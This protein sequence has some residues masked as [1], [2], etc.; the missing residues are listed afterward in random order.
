MKRSP[1]SKPLARLTRRSLLGGL[2]GATALGVPGSLFGQGQPVPAEPA[3][4]D[5]A[6]SGAPFSYDWLVDE[7]RRLARTGFQSTDGNIPAVLSDLS[8]DQYRDIRFRGE[9]ALWRELSPYEVQF[10]HLGSY[11]DRPVAVHDVS[12]GVARPVPYRQQDFHLGRNRI[13]DPLPENLGFAGVRVHYPLNDPEKLDELMVFLGASYFRAL[14]RGTHYGISGR[15]VAVDTGLP[16][17]EEFPAFTQLYLERPQER[18]RPL[19]VY[20]LLDGPSLT[21]AY[22]FAVEPGE[23]TTVDVTARLF[24]RQDIERLGLAPLTSMF[25][26]GP[27]DP[28]DHPDYRPRVHDSQ[29]LLMHSSRGEWVW[30]PLRNPK[31][32]AMSAFQETQPR[33]FGLIQRVRSF[34]S[35]EDLEARYDLRPSLWIEPKGDW[36]EGAVVLIEIPTPDETHDNI[37]AFWTP[38]E[39]A[40][41][42][43]E[44]VLRYV[45]HWGLHGPQQPLAVALET[46]VGRGGL[47]GQQEQARRLRKIVIDFVGGPLPGLPPEAEVVPVLHAQ[48][49]QASEPV[50]QFNPVTGGRRVFFDLP[51]TPE[52]T[53]ELRCRLEL[54]GQPLSETW[55]FQW[56]DI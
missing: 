49:I 12:D 35:Y 38:K 28:A 51:A 3:A 24:F 31:A 23:M 25:D 22:R 46:R 39:R 50:C 48:N 26:H 20:A 7:A 5:T 42:G 45:M 2:L 29:G 40:R 14:G 43:G 21:G 19:T 41:A 4:A 55:S 54:D 17:G 44:A 15:G 9:S 47:P 10:F 27:S 53:A 8:Y 56:S 6:G 16:K 37:V 34:D 32:L 18:G 33:G 13:T 1:L 30:R 52:A 11:F 36:G